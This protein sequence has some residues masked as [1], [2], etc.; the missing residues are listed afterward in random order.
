ML[1]AL[2]VMPPELS[3]VRVTA[4]TVGQMGE[5]T[6]E[7][8]TVEMVQTE[9]S[10]MPASTSATGQA[11]AGTFEASAEIAVVGEVYVFVPPTPTAIRQTVPKEVLLQEGSVLPSDSIGP[12]HVLV[13]VGGEPHAWGGPR[14]RWGKRQNPKS[15]FF[16]LD[17]KEEVRD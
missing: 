2:V 8:P 10:P 12:C 4:S 17:D 5:G 1:T 16:V 6:L 9:P 13:W 3:F 7:A 14:I 15:V 11:K